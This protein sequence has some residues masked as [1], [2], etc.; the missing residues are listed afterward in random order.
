MRL[1]D[2]PR[3]PHTHT[4]PPPRALTVCTLLKVLSDKGAAEKEGS[5]LL[6]LNSI[7]QCFGSGNNFWTGS[8]MLCM[9]LFDTFI[10][11][12]LLIS[13]MQWEHAGRQPSFEVKRIFVFIPSLHLRSNIFVCSILVVVHIVMQTSGFESDQFHQMDCKPL[14]P[15]HQGNAL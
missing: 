13:A 7:A 14:P 3:P 9:S 2:S 1:R 15:W 6:G 10:V 11:Y 4:P 8:I 5:F 12:T